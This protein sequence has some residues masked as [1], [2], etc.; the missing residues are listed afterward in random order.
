M[1]RGGI[2]DNAVGERF[3]PLARRPSGARAQSDCHAFPGATARFRNNLAFTE[4]PS[5][6]G[7]K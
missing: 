6:A 3:P 5:G 7:E 2:H 4:I 1:G